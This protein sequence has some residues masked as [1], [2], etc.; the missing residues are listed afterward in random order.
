MYVF[1]LKKEKNQ[2]NLILQNAIIGV[3]VNNVFHL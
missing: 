3:D 1:R 2:N